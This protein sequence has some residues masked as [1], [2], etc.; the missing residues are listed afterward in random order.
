MSEQTRKLEWFENTQRRLL[1]K[2]THA[3]NLPNLIALAYNATRPAILPT[4]LDLMLKD[5]IKDYG[6]VEGKERT[7]DFKRRLDKARADPELIPLFNEY[8]IVFQCS[9]LED[10]VTSALK[11]WIAKFPET[12]RD[13]EEIARIKISFLKYQQMSDYERDLYLFEELEKE[14]RNKGVYYGFERFEGMFGV[15]GLKVLKLIDSEKERDLKE[16][17]QVRNLLVH[18]GGVVDAHFS[19]T[20]GWLKLKPGDILKTSSEQVIRYNQAITYYAGL[21][22]ERFVIALEKKDAE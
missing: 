15:L 8:N 12:F 17:F 22:A 6:E 18:N 9:V 16:M 4:V 5:N 21:I 2:L 19:K 1:D 13:V 7:E 14:L 3:S 10:F 20:C 11:D